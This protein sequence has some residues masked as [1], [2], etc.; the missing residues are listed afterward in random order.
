M[1]RR[2]EA[3]GRGAATHRASVGRLLR[4][5]FTTFYASLKRHEDLFALTAISLVVRLVWNLQIHKPLDFVYSDMS[6]YLARA[7]ALVTQP[8]FSHPSPPLGAI[9]S[10]GLVDWFAP[11]LFGPKNPSVTLFPYGTHALFAA[12]QAI[13]GKGSGIGLGAS[14]AFIGA[15][16]VAYSFATLARLTP[17]PR[18]R[19][20]VAAVLALYYPWIS[21]GGYALSEA[22]FALCIAAV[23]YH[24][25]R[26]ADEGRPWDALWL[27][28]WLSV[29]AIVR[30][31]I[32][33]SVPLLA[34][35]VAL[36]RRAFPRLRARRAV[37]VAAPLALT[38]ALSA[39]RVHWHTDSPVDADHVVSTNGPINR[40]FGRCH[41]TELTAE[42][43]DGQA[44]FGPPALGSLLRYEATHP[45]ALIKLQPA[46]GAVLTLRG[47]MWDAAP[48]NAIAAECV[49]RTGVVGQLKFAFTHVV[50]LWGYNLI[51]PDLG[52]SPRFREPM[53][54]AGI[55]HA[56]FILPQ[57]LIGIA[58]ALRRT[59][60]RWGL[61][62]MHVGGLVLTSMV[63]FGDS[64][65]RAPYDGLFII[66]AAITVEAGL[67]ALR[68]RPAASNSR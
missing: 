26:F 56:L 1:D 66:L 51:W 3:H 61:L 2:R 9:S 22:P 60:A 15:L 23:A 64:R 31:Q 10:T 49:R 50:L 14:L 34:V 47:H 42:A 62:A 29:G 35:F 46:M 41:N 52:Q 11:R 16:A 57:A 17:N 67:R 7:D 21:L 19:G 39:W 24:S 40:L 53:R 27:G 4:A 33:A 18:T 68:A 5:A 36:R 6:G 48:A 28:L 44:T 13:F 38:L 55:A 43:P 59:Y 20:A 54:V 12:I 37:L 32:L 8:W 58:L 25:L 30:P 65:Y 45:N 63:Y